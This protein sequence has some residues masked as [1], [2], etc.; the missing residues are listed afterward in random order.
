MGIVGQGG[1][2]V[3]ACERCGGTFATQEELERHMQERHPEAE[4]RSVPRGTGGSR[5]DGGA[6]MIQTE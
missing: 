6:G 5:T 3:H 1:G 2:E 4:E